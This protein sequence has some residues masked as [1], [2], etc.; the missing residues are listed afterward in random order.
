MYTH[1][2]LFIFSSLTFELKGETIA[3]KGYA[4]AGACAPAR[5]TP[6]RLVFL[7]CWC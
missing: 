1:T 5:K 2:Q 7:T 4:G 6:G 3:G